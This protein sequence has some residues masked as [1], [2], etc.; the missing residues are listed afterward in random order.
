MTLIKNKDQRVAVLVDV[1]NMYHSAK[2]LYKKRVNFKE[3]LKEAVA[4]R[5][6]IRAIAYVVRTETPEEKTFFEA[7]NKAGFEIKSKD[8]QVFPGGMKKGD[9]DV[10]I[11]IDAVK[12][13][14]QMDSI[15]L[16]AGDGDFIPLIEYLKSNKG[17]QT[18][19]MAFDKSTSGK[20]KEAADGFIDLEKNP[21]KFLI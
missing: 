4:G 16:V 1:Q 5:K 19:I 20:L 14:G 6:L 13:S 11:A 7:L 12:L 15:I 9:W 2:A 8:L 10:G 17:I 18:E 3:I 21:R